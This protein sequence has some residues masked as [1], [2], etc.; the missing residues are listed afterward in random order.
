[1][2]EVGRGKG[3]KEKESE[4]RGEQRRDGREYKQDTSEDR[5]ID[6]R[7]PQ[8]G[9]DYSIGKKSALGELCVGGGSS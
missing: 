7:R 9:A 4:E 8:V 5:A 2:V 1:M 3:R 6:Y